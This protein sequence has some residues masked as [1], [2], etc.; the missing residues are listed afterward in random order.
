MVQHSFQTHQV[1][2]SD[3]Q[4]VC[5]DHYARGHTNVIIIA[6]GFFNSRK[7]VLLKALGESLLDSYDVIIMDFRGHGDSPGLFYWTTKEYLD[8]EAVLKWSASRYSQIGVIGFSLG[9][10]TSIITAAKTNLI[11]SLVSVSGPT[12]FERI[13]YRFW[14]LDIENDIFFNLGEK[15]RTGKGVRLGPFW[16]KKE[17][18]IDLV[19]ELTVP[20]FFIHGESDWLIKPNHSRELYDHTNPNIKK[21]LTMIKNGPH[22]EYLMRE[23][24]NKKE[25]VALIREWFAQTLGEKNVKEEKK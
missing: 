25:F 12:T 21:R 18:P 4:T 16:L 15:G 24:K 2:T 8:L 13:D 6:H 3:G 7:S 17:R 11:T 22:A 20:I 10:A 1:K 19:S 23:S 5:F 14:E 9:A